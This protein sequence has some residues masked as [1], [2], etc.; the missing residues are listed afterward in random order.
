MNS[1]GF[2]RIKCRVG[3]PEGV[4]FKEVDMLTDMGAFHPIIPPD[5]AKELGIEARYKV[6]LTLADRRLVEA[7]VGLAHFKLLD[8]EGVFQVAVTEVPEPLLGVTVLEGLGVRVDPSNGRVE[9][10]RPYGLA[11]L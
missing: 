10:S 7:K 8:R 11:A 3:N 2:V 5:L 6:S 4:P 1:L 9:Y